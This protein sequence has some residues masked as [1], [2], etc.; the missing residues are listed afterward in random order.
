MDCSIVPLRRH[1]LFL[2]ST[3]DFFYPLVD[4]PYVQGQIGAC[5]VLSDMYAMGVVH[6]DNVLMVLAVSQTMEVEYRDIVTRKMIEGFCDKCREA[7]VECTGGQTIFNPAP[8]IGGT[9]MSTCTTEEYILP[10]RAEPGDILVLT[11]PLGT[12]VAVNLN[13]WRQLANERWSQAL[14]VITLDEVSASYLLASESMCRL[15][16]TAAE[17]LHKYNA[18]ACTD[19][20]GFGIMGHAKNLASNQ[21]RNVDFEITVLPIINKLAEV[22]DLFPFF[23]LR[24]GYSAETSGG[25][26]IALPPYSVQNYID[27]IEHRE[28]LKVWIV[29]RVVDAQNEKNQARLSSDVTY[30]SVHPKI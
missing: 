15:N 28:G 20:T 7:G 22:S 16:R 9:A 12:Q 19:V 5:N 13:E 25:L 6:I 17:L 26:L 3:C 23:R 2:I 29:G 11:K 24:Q 8:I 1:G 14:T 10:V 30:I 18:H 21:I 27:E 4:D